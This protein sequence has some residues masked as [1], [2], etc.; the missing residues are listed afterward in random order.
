[1]TLIA[2][3]QF[4]KGAYKKAAEGLLVK[5]CRDRTRS[6]GFKLKKGR[7]RLDNLEIR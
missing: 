7:F 2:T 5:E 1:M 3:F 6:N 4:L